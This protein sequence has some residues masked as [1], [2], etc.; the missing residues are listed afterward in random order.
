MAS[1]IFVLL[2]AHMVELD[3]FTLHSNLS[4]VAIGSQNHKRAATGLC[5][6][7]LVCRP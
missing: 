6:A 5:V 2:V 4:I 1:E 3:A 7:S